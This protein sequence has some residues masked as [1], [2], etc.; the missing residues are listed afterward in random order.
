MR[1]DNELPCLEKFDMKIFKDRFKLDLDQKK[2]EDHVTKIV[3]QS[4]NN[5]FTKLYDDFQKMTNGILP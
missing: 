2:I 5:Q 4:A 3:A 1:I